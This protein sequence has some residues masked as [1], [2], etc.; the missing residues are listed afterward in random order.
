MTNNK[1]GC[2]GRHDP[3]QNDSRDFTGN[4]DPLRGW[5]ELGKPARLNRQQKRS[6]RRESG[7]AI[8]ADLLALLIL[9]AVAWLMLTGAIG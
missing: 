5:H 7:G 9:A 1:K 6:W 8:S 2:T 4:G 3:K